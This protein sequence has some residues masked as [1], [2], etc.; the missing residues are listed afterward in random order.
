MD[1]LF[2][3]KEN[4]TSIAQEAIAGASTFMAMSYIVFV[5]PAVL[6]KVGMDFGAV[7]VATILSSV[8]A[9][10]LMGILANYPIALAPA[11]GHNFFFVYTVVLTLSIPWQKALGA[12]F[13]SGSLFVLLS[14]FGFR[15]SI[16][17]SVPRSLKNSIAVGIGLLIAMVGLEWSG[18]VVDNPGTLVGLGNLSDTHVLI[19]LAGVLF[20]SILMVLRVRGAVLIGIGIG[21]VLSL[22]AGLVEYHGIIQSPPSLSP[23]LFKLDISGLL[24]SVDI[25]TVIFVFFFLDLFDTVGTLIGI[26]E[27]AGFIKENRLPRARQALLSDALGTVVGAVLGTSTVTSYIESA[28]GVSEG[29]RTGLS[30]IFTASFMLLT[31]FFY[32]LVEMI[33]MGIETD[34]GRYLNPIISPVLIIIGSIMLKGVK[35]I[36]WDEPSEAIPSFITM[37]IMPV[38]FSITDGIAFGFISYSLLKTVKGDFK[39]VPL[40]VHILAVLLLLRYVLLMNG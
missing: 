25:L 4:N 10:L 31:L 8:I 26:S 32:P 23:T 5:Q 1:R 12:V 29:G 30:N 13:I 19:S 17:D 6:S 39:E 36:D 27:E 37:I 3:L 14:F 24:N 38:T 28:A 2:R 7:M 35:R 34:G 20:I 18:I 33:G 21:T 16:I 9:T 40:I 22:L 15:E 11:M